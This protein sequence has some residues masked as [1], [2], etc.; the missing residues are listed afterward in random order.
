MRFGAILP[1]TLLFG[2]VKHF[3]E[4]GNVFEQQGIK[5]YVFTPEGKPAEWFNYT[6]KTEKLS[7]LSQYTFDLLFISEEVFLPDLL[8]S[9][10]TL[11]V[12]YHISQKSIREVL[13]HKEIHIMA[14]SS[15][16]YNLI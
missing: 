4:L 14:N 15:T 3:L 1:H 13:K 6:G 8:A 9:K 11:K 2:G 5:F 10:S 16:V 7:Q 12:F